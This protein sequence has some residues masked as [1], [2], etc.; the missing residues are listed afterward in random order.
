MK[1]KEVEVLTQRRE[2][3]DVNL[4]QIQQETVNLRHT[5]ETLTRDKVELEEEKMLAVMS[6]WTCEG[7]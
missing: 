4:N 3:L 6:L 5:I 2:S 7:N 1:E